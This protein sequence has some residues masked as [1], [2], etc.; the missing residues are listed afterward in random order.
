MDV[1]TADSKKKPLSLHRSGGQFIIR[2]EDQ[3]LISS[4]KEW[5][6]EFGFHRIHQKMLNLLQFDKCSGRLQ[7]S[8][9]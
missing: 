1:L 4:F 2:I 5:I 7:Q 3:V 9:R 6:L 8:R